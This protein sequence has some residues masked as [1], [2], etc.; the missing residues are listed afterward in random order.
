MN[1]LRRLRG[2]SPSAILQ[3]MAQRLFVVTNAEALSFPLLESDIADSADPQPGVRERWRASGD[4]QPRVAWVAFP[5][6]PGSGGHTTLFR[7]MEAARTAGFQ[8]TLVLYNRYGNDIDR[9][10]QV[11]RSSWPWLRCEITGLGDDLSGY[12]AVV[13][14]SWPTAHAVARRRLQGQP[15]LYFIQDFEP[16]FYPRGAQ[17]A[18]AEDSYRLGLRAIALGRMV[19]GTLRDELGISSAV[20]PFGC[21]SDVYRVLEDAAPR[22]GIV[23]YAKRGNDRRGYILALRALRQFHLLRPDEP[24][25]VY[26]DAIDAG[27]LPV[28]HHGNLRPNDLNAL[29]NSVICGLALSFTNI[30]LVAEELLRA[31][32]VPVINDS[33]LA[34]AD[35]VNPH[36]RWATPTSHALANALVAAV[37]EYQVT[38]SPAVVSESVTTK[39]WGHTGDLVAAMI[40]EEI[41]AARG[42]RTT[43]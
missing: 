11:V 8:N 29:Y 5:P 2:K 39:G 36:V 42:I 20:V 27:G 28:T 35:L 15:A 1:V 12:D 19:E 13:A 6:G 38:S 40:T 18:L 21:D 9:S 33:A 10:A 43:A 23:F 32:V 22:R 34:R 17:Y 25:H 3:H 31:G 24:I 37:D 7:M 4:L 26:G 30:S 41:R 16:Y 14:S